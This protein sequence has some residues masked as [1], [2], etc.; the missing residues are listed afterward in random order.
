MQVRHVATEMVTAKHCQNESIA[1]KVPM[2]PGNLIAECFFSGE[3]IGQASLNGA[4]NVF[5][6]HFPEE[7]AKIYSD[8]LTARVTFTN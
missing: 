6:G 3:L 5:V 4:T 1:V 2:I 8:N 7:S